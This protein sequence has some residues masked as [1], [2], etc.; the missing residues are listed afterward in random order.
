MDPRKGH[1]LRLRSLFFPRVIVD[2]Q[3]AGCCSSCSFHWS[4]EEWWI[5]S[6]W[7]TKPFFFYRNNRS[8]LFPFLIV[9]SFSLLGSILLAFLALWWCS[10]VWIFC[11]FLHCNPSAKLNLMWFWFRWWS[12]IDRCGDST[13]QILKMIEVW[14]GLLRWRRMVLVLAIGDLHIPHRAPDLPA[15][16]KQMLVPGKIQHILCVGSL[17]I[18]VLIFL[19][20]LK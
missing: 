12:Y 8:L 16:F 18:E 10:L 3:I 2:P 20:P 1:P 4:R 19:F 17:C 13:F 14:L 11:L 15:K 9:F 7:F 6:K 5:D